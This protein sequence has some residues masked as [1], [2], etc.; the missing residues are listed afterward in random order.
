MQTNRDGKRVEPLMT[1]IPEMSQSL[2]IVWQWWKRVGV[3]RGSDG[4]EG[5]G[6]TE[7]DRGI[8]I[9]HGVRKSSDGAGGPL[10]E[11]PYDLRTA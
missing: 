1:L 11:P 5:V 10:T 7:S 6:N 8:R 2:L 9:C 3:S 4:V